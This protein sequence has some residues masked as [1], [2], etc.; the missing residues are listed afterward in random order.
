MKTILFTVL[1]M[2][3]LSTECRAT[4]IIMVDIKTTPTSIHYSIN[5]QPFTLTELSDWMRGWIEA[6][7]DEGP[8]LIGPDPQTTFLTVF[9]LL[10]RLKASGVKHFQ[11]IAE[12]SQ[13]ETDFTKRALTTRAEDVK[14]TT[15]PAVEPRP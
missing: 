8:I 1:A 15:T 9:K 10:E 6:V 5:N 2:T 11:V 3:L 14:H 12:L 7:G 13:T 4:V